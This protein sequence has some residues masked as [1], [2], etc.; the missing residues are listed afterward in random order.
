MEKVT[1]AASPTDTL[2][3]IVLGAGLLL[4]MTAGAA[5]GLKR[6]PL[7]ALASLIALLGAACCAWLFGSALG[8]AVF[9]APIP[10]ILRGALGTVTT[11]AVVFLI[12]FGILWWRGR[13]KNNSG[14]PEWPVTGCLVGCWVGILWYAAGLVALLALAEIGEIWKSASGTTHAVPLVLRWPMRVKGALASQPGTEALARLDPLPE[15]PARIFKKALAVMRSPTA[16][17]RLQND[18]GV[19]ALAAHPAFY[20]LIINA[21]IKEIVRRGDAEALFSHPRVVALLQDEEF[22]RRLMDAEIEPMLDRALARP[23]AH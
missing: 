8:H 12:V 6:G 4:A 17:R 18:E 15:R 14:D 9:G 2:I 22:Q 10:W 11:G 20:P 7:R 13:S 19:R 5:R 16:F 23:P 21:E 3:L 1:A